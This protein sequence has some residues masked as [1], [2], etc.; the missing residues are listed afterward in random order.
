M[1][2]MAIMIGI[3]ASGKSSFCK[4]NL[5][6]YIRINLD[7]LNTSSFGDGKIFIKNI[8]DA[9]KIRTAERGDDAL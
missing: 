5:Q 6:N 4:S 7:E 2:T 3:Q 8:D 1:A 9:V